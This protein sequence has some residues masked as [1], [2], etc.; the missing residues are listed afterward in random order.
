M[1]LVLVLSVCTMVQMQHGISAATAPRYAGNF[2]DLVVNLVQKVF[3]VLTTGFFQLLS[4]IIKTG[5]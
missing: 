1:N 2:A 5:R 4:S 3:L